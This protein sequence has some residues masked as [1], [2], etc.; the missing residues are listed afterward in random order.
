M[1]PYV[2][3]TLTTRN[4][5][6]QHGQL[7]RKE[8]ML[9]D[10]N[11]WPTINV[12][13]NK[14]GT[15]AGTYPSNVISH[16]HRQQQG[17]AQAP[18]AATNQAGIGPP[19]AKRARPTIPNAARPETTGLQAADNR[20]FMVEDDEDVSRGDLLDFLTPREISAMR[21]KQH[22]EWLGEVFRSPYDTHQ[23]VPGELGL[24]R[25]GE[26]EA[27]TRDF[28]NAP[29]E[30]STRTAN[31][32]RPARVGRMESGKA[33]EFSKVATDRI[34]D[35]N[36]EIER[37]KRQHAKRMAK[38]AKGAD[39]RE[40]EKAL[41]TLA[42]N[43]NE[44]QADGGRDRNNVHGDSIATIQSKVEASL[45]K[46]IEKLVETECVQKGGLMDKLDESEDAEQDF[47]FS[48]HAADLSGQIPAFQTPQDPTSSIEGT[49][50]LNVEPP[51]AAS[52]TSL[53]AKG[54][55]G[56][57]VIDMPVNRLQDAPQTKDGEAE[58]WIIVNKENDNAQDDDA[59]NEALPDLDAFTNDAAMD[60][61]MEA[62][63][64]NDEETAGEL[65]DFAVT[66]EGE[67]EADFAAND[68]AEGVDFANLDTAGEALSGYEAEESM[69]MD[70][71]A[72]LGLDDTAFGDAFVHSNEAGSRQ[73][74]DLGTS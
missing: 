29:T 12:P 13:G 19:P 45:G 69:G 11:S 36:G 52:H 41:R 4:F 61:N 22:H 58:D 54:D 68:F 48:D 27:L 3:S 43:P 44:G 40:A 34:A 65:P 32:T 59:L 2:Q 56:P 63:G 30:P 37:I 39:I 17:Y 25:K 71:G 1:T 5:L 7:V 26:L 35:I 46:N 49:P 15:Q 23:I 74:D 60:T 42:V 18:A 8:F 31:G 50:G 21:Y 62:S 72:D 66:A 14:A 55:E 47:D 53:T 67:L 57:G 64:D 6:Q 24:G 73:D 51:T 70:D 33:D 28:F 16:L 10:R 20:D 9:H 38:L